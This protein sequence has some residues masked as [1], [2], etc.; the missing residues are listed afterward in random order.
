[1]STKRTNRDP[2]KQRTTNRSGTGRTSKQTVK[3]NRVPSNRDS[4]R[5]RTA[6][7]SRDPAQGRR[8]GRTNARVPPA[9][10]TRRQGKPSREEKKVDD[11]KLSSNGTR[12]KPSSNLQHIRTESKA[13]QAVSSRERHSQEVTV[14]VA[15][16]GDSQTGKTSLMVKYVEDRFDE[17]YIETL[18]VNFMEKTV[19][20]QNVTITFSLWDLGGQNEYLTLMPLACCDAKVILFVFDLT[21]KA[22]LVAVKMW[23]RSS[24]KENKYAIPFLIGTKFD[25]FDKETMTFKEE[26]TTQARKFAKAMKAPLIFCSSSHSIN[27]KKIFQTIITKVFSV[28][29][30]FDEIKRVGQPILEYKNDYRSKDKKGKSK[31]SDKAKKAKSKGSKSRE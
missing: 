7:N 12:T 10:T 17:D 19:N 27:I 11:V 23:Y 8:D 24:R 21:R 5:R 14:K 6:K 15:M 28:P 29:G 1:M 13:L 25:L 9:S 26:V 31:S 4:N 18:G 2:S 16:I 20:L 22:S 30:R 3:S